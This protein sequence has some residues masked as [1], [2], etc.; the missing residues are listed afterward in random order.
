MG[1]LRSLRS[2]GGTAAPC[3]ARTTSAEDLCV[4]IIGGGLAGQY[5]AMPIEDLGEAVGMIMLS[6][7]AP[8]IA[9]NR[10]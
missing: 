1:E 2:E 9:K 5:A 7:I 8:R 6:S 3:I 4:G 10:S